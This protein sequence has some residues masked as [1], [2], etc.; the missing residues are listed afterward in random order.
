MG[1]AESYTMTMWTLSGYLYPW[2][3]GVEEGIEV[4]WRVL[5]GVGGGVGTRPWCWF[6]GGA[7]WPLATVS[8]S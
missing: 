7:Y 5:S 6:V 1:Q 8:G 2:E 3:S 4:A